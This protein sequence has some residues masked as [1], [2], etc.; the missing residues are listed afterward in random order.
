MAYPWSIYRDA[1]GY[2]FTNLRVCDA[3]LQCEIGTNDQ[4]HYEAEVITF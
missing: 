4:K 1:M 2:L 3:L